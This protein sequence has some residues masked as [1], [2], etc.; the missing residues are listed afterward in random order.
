MEKLKHIIRLGGGAMES[1]VSFA[2]WELTPLNRHIGLHSLFLFPPWLCVYAYVSARVYK[3][4]YACLNQRRPPGPSIT[5]HLTLSLHLLNQQPAARVSPV[6]TLCRA[7]L[8]VQ[9]PCEAAC[10]GAGIWTR[11]SV[12]RQHAFLPTEPAL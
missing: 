2:F 7:G 12:F 4:M 9:R 6:S 8:E 10:V 11:V 5:L 1:L 3:C